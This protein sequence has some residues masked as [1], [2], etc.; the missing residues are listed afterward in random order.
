MIPRVFYLNLCLKV[1]PPT[2]ESGYNGRSNAPVSSYTG[3]V[4]VGVRANGDIFRYWIIGIM[5]VECEHIPGE[6]ITVAHPDCEAAGMKEICCSTCGKT[7]ETEGIGA[8][9]H[10][11]GAWYTITEA[12]Y[13]NDGLNRR[14]CQRDGC[15]YY[16]TGVCP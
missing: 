14:D 7:L 6:W 8:L 13:E 2:I 16:D 15:D 1:N 4:Q 10:D 11:M 9:G 12:T 5:P 3:S